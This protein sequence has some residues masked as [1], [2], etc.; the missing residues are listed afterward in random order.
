LREEDARRIAVR[1]ANT[2]AVGRRR[3]QVA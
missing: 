3:T 1:P 2:D